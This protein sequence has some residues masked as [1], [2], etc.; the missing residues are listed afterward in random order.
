[1]RNF[2]NW[3]RSVALA[4]STL[5]LG[6]ALAISS[7]IS[8]AQAASLGAINITGGAIIG[9]VI[10][11]SPDNDTISFTAPFTTVSSS[12]PFSG[13][14]ASSISTINLVLTGA[15]VEVL[16][17]TVTPYS[18]TTTAPFISFV[19]GSNFVVDDPSIA[20]RNFTPGDDEN[21]VGYTLPQLRGTF[22]SNT[23]DFLSEGILTANQISG[24]GING[25]F[26]LTLSAVE[27]GIGQPVPEPATAGA[28][29]ALGIGALF[30]NN[31][32]KKKKVKINA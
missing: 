25:S 5:A 13:L 20:G 15:G 28:L 10:D 12:G 30:T 21:I 29:A 32:V 8:S 14:V 4:S 26:S 23:G 22:F 6:S 7:S 1:M 9:N 11:I 31:V 17:T 27:V 2:Q 16:G 3:G 18:A 24:T 19:D